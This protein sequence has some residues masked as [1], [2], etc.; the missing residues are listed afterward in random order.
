M[1]TL[2]ESIIGGSADLLRIRA[3]Q[4]RLKS[5]S[6]AHQLRDKKEQIKSSTPIPT[7]NI[8]TTQSATTPNQWFDHQNPPLLRYASQFYRRGVYELHLSTIAT[9]IHGDKVTDVVGQQQQQHT[10]AKLAITVSLDRDNASAVLATLLQYHA[11]CL[12]K[13]EGLDRECADVELRRRRRWRHHHQPMMPYSIL[14]LPPWPCC[15]LPAPAPRGGGMAYINQLLM[16]R[17]A[18][19]CGSGVATLLVVQWWWE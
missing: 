1:M 15:L 13:N 7:N 16:M 6:H 17:V 3:V 14:L 19:Q 4:Q 12:Q 11:P 5:S 8:P 10:W 2:A 9:S 18:L